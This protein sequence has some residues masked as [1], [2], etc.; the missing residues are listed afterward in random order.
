MHFFSVQHRH[1]TFQ[2]FWNV[3]YEGRGFLKKWRSISSEN[4][5]PEKLNLRGVV[6]EKCGQRL[7]CS[8]TPL[9]P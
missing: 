7:F 5:F 2:H 8:K 4:E 3:D 6:F 9:L 1:T